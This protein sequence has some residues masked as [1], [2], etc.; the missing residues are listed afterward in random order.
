MKNIAE[1]DKNLA[2]EGAIER[3][4]LRFMMYD[5]PPFVFMVFLGRMVCFVGYQKK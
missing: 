5:K 2:V 4:G 1:I 3:D